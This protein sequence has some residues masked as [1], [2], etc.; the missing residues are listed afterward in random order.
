[1]QSS[2]EGFT[3][4]ECPHLDRDLQEMDASG[5]WFLIRPNFEQGVIE[6]AACHKA[7]PNPKNISEIYFGSSAQDIY[8]GIFKNN[9]PNPGTAYVTS[10]THAAYLGKELKKA[11]IALALGIK[12]TYQE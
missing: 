3:M 11:E 8:Q 2:I 6:V 12:E 10:L 7:S 5:Y 1:M 9:N 4:I